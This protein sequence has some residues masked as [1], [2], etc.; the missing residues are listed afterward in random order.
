MTSNMEF[1]AF[2]N[3][4]KK[5]VDEQD[6]REYL[7]CFGTNSDTSRSMILN[8]EVIMC[9]TK[10]REGIETV[11][12]KET[13][14]WNKA[15]RLLKW[16]EDILKTSP[17]VSHGFHIDIIK[18]SFIDLPN[19][20]LLKIITLIKILLNLMVRPDN[21]VKMRNSL[22]IPL[23]ISLRVHILHISFRL[24]ERT[25]DL[26]VFNTMSDTFNDVVNSLDT[27]FS[28]TEILKKHSNDLQQYL[29][30]TEDKC[31]VC[32]AE[33][34]ISNRGD[35]AILSSCRHFYCL[36]CATKWFEKK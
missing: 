33:N 10:L 12:E 31:S 21:Y 6:A 35:F 36:P 11:I 27:V 16:V 28:M 9:L 17:Y 22:F 30:I 13:Q 7:R 32:L 2:K 8:E 3:L 25:R 5:K 29:H 15:V 14:W 34:S 19:Q 24:Y 20:I 1:E 26:H 18:K 4:A 23:T